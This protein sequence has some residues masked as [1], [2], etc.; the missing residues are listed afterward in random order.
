MNTNIIRAVGMVWYAD[1]ATYYR[2]R[3]LFSDG[4]LL[5]ATFIEWR[6]KAEQGFKHQQRQGFITIKAYIDPGTFPDWCSARG[7]D[8]NA[9]ARMEFANFIAYQEAGT[10]H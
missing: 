6:N 9:K 1:A 3:A 4:H 10:T 5:P 7:L 8:L 2:C